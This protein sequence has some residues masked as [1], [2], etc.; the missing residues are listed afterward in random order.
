M[1]F[2]FALDKRNNSSI[3]ISY[4]NRNYYSAL[5]VSP[6]FLYIFLCFSLNLSF[7]IYDLLVT[8]IITKIFRRNIQYNYAKKWP[9]RQ[10]Y[11]CIYRWV[12]VYCVC[13]QQ[14]FVQLLYKNQYIYIYIYLFFQC[15]LLSY[16]I[17]LK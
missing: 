12:N 8:I 17:I 16:N 1:A 3:F 10:M 4:Y 11:L 7:Y 9:L 14:Y 6:L 15:V 2:W 5:F 13:M